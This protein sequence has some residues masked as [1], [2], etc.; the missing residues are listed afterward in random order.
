MPAQSVIAELL[1][2]QSHVPPRGFMRRLFGVN[3]LSQE[4]KSWYRG[5]LGELEVARVLAG[6]GPEYTVLHAVPVGA[7]TSDID[8]IVIGPTGVFTVNTKNHSGK[9]VWVA[10]RTFMVSGA[11]QPH[12]RNSVFEAKRAARLLSQETG[13]PVAVKPLIVVVD[14]AELNVKEKPGGVEVL[15][16]R[17][18]KRWFSR[19]PRRLDPEEAETIVAAACRPGLW[20]PG[21]QDDGDPAASMARFETLRRAVRSAERRR[22][23]WA[24]AMLASLFV[25]V[26]AAYHVYLGLLVR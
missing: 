25:S 23:G 18:L 22:I 8:H 4:T 17:G 24:F 21:M 9:K 12:I 6:L 1:D 26:P 10:G 13:R 14:A 7:G 19:L 16:S 20:H 15:S 11:K 5:A 2:G 3:P